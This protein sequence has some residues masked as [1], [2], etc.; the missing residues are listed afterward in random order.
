[1][2]EL[3]KIGIFKSAARQIAKS[4]AEYLNPSCCL[5]RNEYSEN[6]KEFCKTIYSYI[7]YKEQYELLE[8]GEITSITRDEFN[9]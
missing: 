3:S 5:C 2:A 6:Y 4:L 7:H 1:M 9:F 8:K